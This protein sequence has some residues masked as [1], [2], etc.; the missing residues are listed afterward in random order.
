[1]QR[2]EDFMQE[3]FRARTEMDRS[4]ERLY[5]PLAERFLAPDYTSWDLKQSVRGSEAEAI[6]DIRTSETGAEVFTRGWLDQDHRVRYQLSASADSWRIR[7][8]TI[9]CGVCHGSGKRKNH[10]EDCRICKGEGWTLIGK[11][12]DA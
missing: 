7:T 3:Y 12:R 10:H 11:R 2:I 5:A 1:M 4:I 9:E 8:I 6:L